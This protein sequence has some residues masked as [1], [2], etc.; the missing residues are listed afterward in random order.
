LVRLMIKFKRR[1]VL[2]CSSLLETAPRH[3]AE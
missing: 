1:Y 3:S 2:D